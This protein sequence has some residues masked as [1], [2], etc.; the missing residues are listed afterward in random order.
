MGMFDKD[1]QY[2][3]RLDG[4]FAI[5]EH[6]ILYGVEIPND[7]IETDFGAAEYVKMRVSK[8]KDTE[9]RYEVQTLAS[10]IVDKCKDA[11]SNDFPAIVKLDRVKGRYRDNTLVLQFVSPLSRDKTPPAKAATENRPD[12]LPF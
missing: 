9:H 10:A 8:L 2:G 5:G 4:E 7:T 11:D 12:D 6:F 1:K 3:M